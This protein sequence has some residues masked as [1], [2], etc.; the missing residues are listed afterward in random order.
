MKKAAVPTAF[1]L[2]IGTSILHL[3]PLLMFRKQTAK[4]FL[5]SPYNIRYMIITIN[6]NTAHNRMTV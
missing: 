5:K 2:A 1:V 4:P 3:I 6:T